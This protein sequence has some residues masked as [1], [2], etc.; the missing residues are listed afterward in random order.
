MKKARTRYTDEER[1]L[2]D[3]L[4]AKL[5]ARGVKRLPRDW[6]LK[7]LSM[8]R[9]MLS[10]DNS[11]SLDE[12]KACIDWCFNH[13]YWSDKVD[14]LARADNLWTKYVLQARGASKEEPRAAAKKKAFI[15]S[16]YT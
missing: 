6:H 3:Y 2:V 16:L 12:W 14:H 5:L 10:G 11:P 1:L 8:A 4:K 15:R 13:K 9:V 7:Q